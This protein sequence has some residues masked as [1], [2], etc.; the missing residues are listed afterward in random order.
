MRFGNDF[1][2]KEIEPEDKQKSTGLPCEFID[3]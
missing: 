1:I 3:K 2:S